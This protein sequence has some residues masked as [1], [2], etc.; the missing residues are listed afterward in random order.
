L[1]P[2]PN[3]PSSGRS[4]TGTPRAPHS[5]FYE[6]VIPVLIGGLVVVLLIILVLT[7]GAL[8]GVIPTR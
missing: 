1:N 7:I 6:R 5:F 4:P 8:V 3:Q 2:S